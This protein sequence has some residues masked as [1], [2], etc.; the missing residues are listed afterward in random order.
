MQS[1]SVAGAWLRARVDFSYT[2]SHDLSPARVRDPPQRRQVLDATISVLRCTSHGTW[3]A[4]GGSGF[5]P[6]NGES[7]MGLKRGALNAMVA[8]AL[9]IGVAHAD[10][11]LLGSSVTISADNGFGSG[12]NLCKHGAAAGTVGAGAELTGADWTGVCVGYYSADVTDTQLILTGI[13]RGNYSFASLTLIFVGVTITDASFAGYT[14]D[15]FF[16]LGDANDSNFTPV[17]TFTDSTV[18]IVWDTLD[19]DFQFSFN[20]PGNGG[21][22]PFGSA[23]FSISTGGSQ[24]PEPGTLLLL[25]IG[26]VVLARFSASRKQIAA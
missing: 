7:N 17:V 23:I 12:S 21:S 22:E 8:V 1:R 2:G 14:A 18:S 4:A 15:F 24:V 3:L 25:A 20:G 16:P 19:D 10:P 5:L 11:G 9:A 6:T 13:E 26:L